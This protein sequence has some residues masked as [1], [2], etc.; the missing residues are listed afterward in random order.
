MT[1][2]DHPSAAA[3]R[4]RDPE[5]KGSAVTNPVE[6]APSLAPLVCPTARLGGWVRSD[7]GTRGQTV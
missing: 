3:V 4:I 2:T 7:Y 1:G 6:K 5:I